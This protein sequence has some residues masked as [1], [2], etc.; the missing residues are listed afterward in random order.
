MNSKNATERLN[1]LNDFAFKKIMGEKGSEA[2]LISFLNAVLS[3][4]G[5]APRICPQL[6][7]SANNTPPSLISL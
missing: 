1:P 3:K 4:T 5:K 7:T 6:H 2:L